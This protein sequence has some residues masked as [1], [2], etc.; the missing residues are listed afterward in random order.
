MAA[1]SGGG[2]TS[3]ANG[4]VANLSGLI[5]IEKVIT[6]TTRKMRT[7]EEPGQ[8]YHFVSVEKFLDLKKQGVFLETTE[9][10][11]NFYGSPYSIVPTLKEG[12][13]FIMITDITGAKNFKKNLLPESITIWLTIPSLKVLRERLEKRNTEN[14]EILNKRLQ[15]AETEIAQESIEHFFDYHVLN[16]DLSKAIQNVSEIIKNELGLSSAK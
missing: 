15:L 7:N 13:S 14:A 1:P 16:D 2:K 9:Y 8:D 6:F 5:S 10:N 12:K 11:G 4:V 3:V